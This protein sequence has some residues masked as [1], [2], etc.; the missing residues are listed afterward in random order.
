MLSFSNVEMGNGFKHL[1]ILKHRDVQIC[2]LSR[3][4]SMKMQGWEPSYLKMCDSYQASF[5]SQMARL[6]NFVELSAAGIS[7]GCPGHPVSSSHSVFSKEA[8]SSEE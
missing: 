8:Q 4:K 5:S 2:G 7:F 3:R 6:P 1:N